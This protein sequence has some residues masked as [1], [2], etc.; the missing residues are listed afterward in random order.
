[1]TAWLLLALVVAV[2]VVLVVFSWRGSKPKADQSTYQAIVG[3]HAIR[4][5]LE[6]AQVRTELRR[7]A[8]QMR[9]ELRA[10]LDGRERRRP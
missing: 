2:A 9:R 3:L 10:E 8:A 1:M 4:R 6:V 7:D 5:R